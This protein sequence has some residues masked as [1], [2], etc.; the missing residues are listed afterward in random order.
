MATLLE[1]IDRLLNTLAKML[2]GPIEPGRLSRASMVGVDE[3]TIR[4][5]VG[6]LQHTDFGLHHSASFERVELQVDH[7][8]NLGGL[9]GTQVVLAKPLGLR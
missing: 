7:K 5:P 1:R 2:V 3:M 9:P 6:G 4:D 8:F